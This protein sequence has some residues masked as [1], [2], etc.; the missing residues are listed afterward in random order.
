MARRSGIS[1]IGACADLTK[2]CWNEMHRQG[3]LAPSFTSGFEASPPDDPDAMTVWWTQNCASLAS[4]RSSP[5]EP[6]VDSP[7]AALA[8]RTGSVLPR[9]L[10]PG[11]GSLTAQALGTPDES[12]TGGRAPGALAV[13]VAIRRPV[14][15]PRPEG[16]R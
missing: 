14:K 13:L 15:L 12:T 10:V 11:C 7:L 9:V 8:T 6:A 2:S 5:G 1:R 16:H 4:K 3:G